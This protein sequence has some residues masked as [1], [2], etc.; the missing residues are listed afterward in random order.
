[1]AKISMT[2]ARP[3]AFGKLEI[4]ITT[5]SITTSELPFRETQ[6]RDNAALMLLIE[7]SD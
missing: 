1:M 7:Q 6:L 4:S 2:T 5:E 3:S